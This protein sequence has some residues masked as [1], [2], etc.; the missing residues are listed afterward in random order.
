[1]LLTNLPVNAVR[2][3][4]TDL[5]SGRRAAEP[6]KHCSGISSGALQF[7]RYSR[8]YAC[9]ALRLLQDCEAR[10]PTRCVPRKTCAGLFERSSALQRGRQA[11]RVHSVH[12]GLDRTIE[13]APDRLRRPASAACKRFTEGY[14]NE[15]ASLDRLIEL[16][17]FLPVFVLFSAVWPI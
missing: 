5:K 6:D 13:P 2:L 9:F 11:G 15:I 12:R 3:N 14:D 17:N 7:K 10:K 1:M 8:H 16:E 4:Q